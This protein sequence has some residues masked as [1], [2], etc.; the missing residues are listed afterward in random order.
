MLSNQWTKQ[1]SSTN[2]L[3]KFMLI[4]L[5]NITNTQT[6]NKIPLQVDSQTAES[7][8]QKHTKSHSKV[9]QRIQSQSSLNLNLKIRTK[10][11]ILAIDGKEQLIGHR[12]M[13]ERAKE[14]AHIFAGLYDLNQYQTLLEYVCSD[15]VDYEFGAIQNDLTFF[16]HIF[17]MTAWTEIRRKLH[18]TRIEWNAENLVWR[19]CLQKCFKKFCFCFCRKG[20]CCKPNDD[21]FEC[22]WAKIEFCFMGSIRLGFMPIIFRFVYIALIVLIIYYWYTDAAFVSLYFYYAF[23]TIAALELCII[24]YTHWMVTMFKLHT[25]IK[26]GYKTVPQSILCGLIIDDC[27]WFNSPPLMILVHQEHTLYQAVGILRHLLALHSFKLCVMIISA[28]LQVQSEPN[29]SS[30]VIASVVLAVL[31]F[32][33]CVWLHGITKKHYFLKEHGA[34]KPMRDYKTLYVGLVSLL[35]L[36]VL[37]VLTGFVDQWLWIMFINIVYPFVLFLST[38][39]AVASTCVWTLLSI[40]CHYHYL[41]DHFGENRC[42]YWAIAMVIGFFMIEMETR[43]IARSLRWSDMKQTDHWVRGGCLTNCWLHF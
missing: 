6:K 4:E 20:N 25:I 29:T 1:F 8:K 5:E 33:Y 28:L 38:T 27:L 24:N 15:I 10:K 31:L 21:E 35:L 12:L 26:W 14:L 42:I 30:N 34:W 16:Q 36:T 11:A 22:F 9:L 37:N 32:L 13:N 2:K 41:A 19:Q 18:S 7:K 3:L 40:S 39:L 17:K 23:I 43:R